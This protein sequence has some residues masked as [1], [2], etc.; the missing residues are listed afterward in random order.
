MSVYVHKNLCG[1][2]NVYIN[3]CL[4]KEMPMVSKGFLYILDVYLPD[5]QK[6]MHCM[7]STKLG[8]TVSLL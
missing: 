8:N 1:G 3:L 2:Y 4:F 7:H 5:S 6:A